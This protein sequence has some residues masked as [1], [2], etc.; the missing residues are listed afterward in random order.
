MSHRLLPFSPERYHGTEKSRPYFEGWYFKQASP[1]GAFAVIPGLFRGANPSED[2]AFIQVIFS[3]PSKSY[4]VRYPEET[5]SCDT[6]VFELRIAESYFSLDA[7]RLDMKEI[8]L[9]ASLDYSGHI[10]LKKSMLCP[11][12]MGPF[13][14]LP[15]MQCNHGV[16]SLHHSVSGE[17]LCE[18]R[19]LRFDGADGYIEKDWGCAFPENWVWMQCG[20]AEA[21]LMMAVAS[22]PLGIVHFSGLICVLRIQEKQYRFATYNGARM[23][24]LY[25]KSGLVTAEVGRGRHRLRV[26]ARSEQFGSLKAPVKT[27]MDR[28][29]RESI[30]TVCDITLYRDEQMLYSGHFEHGG[31]EMHGTEK[32]IK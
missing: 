25:E 6:H 7:L 16:L 27:G 22:I 2:F 9:K 26:T 1:Q 32:L 30:D 8:G 20:N 17:V 18:E 14:Y 13:A 19:I 15:G 3:S 12:V 31:L 10:P 28:V 21:S 24:G 5:F 4:F 23:L 11:S 29:I